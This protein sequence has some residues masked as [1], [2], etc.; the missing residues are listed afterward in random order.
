MLPPGADGQD[1]ALEVF[2]PESLVDVCGKDAGGCP[3]R[4]S[5]L[6]VNHEALHVTQKTYR[7][8]V[9]Q[10]RLIMRIPRSVASGLQVLPQPCQQAP[11]KN[12]LYHPRVP[13]NKTLLQKPMVHSRVPLPVPSRIR[14]RDNALDI[15]SRTVGTG[16]KV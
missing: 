1:S 14:R 7:L 16:R 9:L 10:G 3:S 15:A 12:M 8:K 13:L 6:C 2:E 4:A 5:H 11:L